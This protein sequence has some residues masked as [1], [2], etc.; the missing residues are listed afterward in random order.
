M[1]NKLRGRTDDLSENLQK[2]TESL[3]KKKSE[4]QNIRTEINNILH[5]LHNRFYEAEGQIRNLENK[6][7][8]N[9]QSEH[10]QE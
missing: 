10:H 3:K 5:G 7:L 2:E 6:V 8:E 1:I 4:M 9:T